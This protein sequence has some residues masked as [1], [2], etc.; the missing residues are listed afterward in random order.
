MMSRHR[1]R[2][3]GDGTAWRVADRAHDDYPCYWSA[4]PSDGHISEQARAANM[5]RQWG[6]RRAPA[7][8]PRIR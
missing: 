4:G 5:G 2:R 1:R 3:H 6:R 8:R 7:V